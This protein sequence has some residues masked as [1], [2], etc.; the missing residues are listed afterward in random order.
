[1][2]APVERPAW[3]R[4]RGAVRRSWRTRRRRLTIPALGAAQP[5]LPVH[6]PPEELRPEAALHLHLRPRMLT[7]PCET[8]DPSLHQVRSLPRM[9]IPPRMVPA[10]QSPL[11]QAMI[12]G[13][14]IS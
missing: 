10:L 1:M 14:A 12:R 2:C 6:S 11:L 7:P 8:A 9:A 5:V 3:V 4:I 13:R